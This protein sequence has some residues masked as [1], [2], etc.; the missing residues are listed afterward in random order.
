MDEVKRLQKFK[1]KSGWTH[2]QIA[3]MMN[4]HYQSCRNWIL[5]KFS[6]S[7]M[8]KEKIE[9]FLELYENPEPE[10]KELR[11]HQNGQ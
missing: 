11:S 7:N 3:A 5:K 4:I 1:Q 10:K 6:P 2:K 8:A 9:K